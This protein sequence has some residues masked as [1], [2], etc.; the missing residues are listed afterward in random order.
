MELLLEQGPA[1]AG[2]V[3]I[4]T[5]FSVAYFPLPHWRRQKLPSAEW[6]QTQVVLPGPVSVVLAQQ[7]PNLQPV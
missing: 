5:V 6:V 7:E 2:S 3:Q 1:L 4:P